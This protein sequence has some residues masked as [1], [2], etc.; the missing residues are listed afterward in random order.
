MKVEKVT[1]ITCEVIIL[2]VGDA[3]RMVA[4]ADSSVAGT[5]IWYAFNPEGSWDSLGA[6][7]ELEAA[8]QASKEQA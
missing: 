1:P 8:Y 3:L 4:P 7:D 6:N 5:P 2:D